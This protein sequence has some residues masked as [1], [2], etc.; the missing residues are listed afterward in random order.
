[1]NEKKPKV[2]FWTLGS[3]ENI[4][5]KYH[6]FN[7]KHRFFNSYSGSKI[8][9]NTATPTAEAHFACVGRRYTKRAS[10]N[11]Y[12]KI[13]THVNFTPNPKRTSFKMFSHFKKNRKCLRTLGRCEHIVLKYCSFNAKYRPFNSYSGYLF[14]KNAIISCRLSTFHV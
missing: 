13:L 9:S 12:E 10:E 11:D 2:S 7:A 3:C 14:L 4:V 6:S 8:F 5:W 1:M